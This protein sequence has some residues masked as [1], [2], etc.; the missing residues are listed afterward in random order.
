MQF[1]WVLYKSTQK[2]RVKVL[3]KRVTIALPESLYDRLQP[4]K[5]HL[6][7]SSICQEALTMAVTHEEIKKQFASDANLVDRLRTEKQILLKKVQQEG[8]ELGIRSA[9]K[10]SYKDFQHFERVRPL[11]DSLDEDV[12]EYLWDYLDS[13]GYPE[14]ARIHDADF[15]HLLE[16]SP[17]S[18]ILFSQGWI[19]GVLSVWAMIKEQVEGED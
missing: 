8:Y 19:D 15:A 6:N 1:N 2:R 3:S 18:R 16:V 10:L 12:L 14:S 7:I 11:A 4:V 17:Q 5:Q 13:H 9:S